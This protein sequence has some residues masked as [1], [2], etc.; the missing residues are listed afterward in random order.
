MGVLSLLTLV[1]VIVI[2]IWRGWNLGVSAVAA[3]MI[4]CMIAGIS[5]S[6]ALRDFDGRMAAQLI[7]S[8]AAFG[9]ISVNGAAELGIKKIMKVLGPKAIP[10]MPWFF[11]LLMLIPAMMGAARPAFVPA[12]A[13]G[14]LVG[15]QLGL[16][17][18]LIPFM[19]LVPAVISPIHPIQ[20]VGIIA[21]D[22]LD[23]QGQ[24]ASLWPAFYAEMVVGF[25]ICLVLYILMKGYKV[26]KD[27]N[28]DFGEEL[29]KFDAKQIMSLLGTVV[30]IVGIVVL[31]LDIGMVGAFMATV[32]FALNIFDRK[33]FFKVLPIDIMITVGGMSV[34]VPI[35]VNMG[36]IDVLMMMLNPILNKYTIVPIITLVAGLVSWLS[37]T[38]TVVLPTFIPI[39]PSMLAAV[40]GGIEFSTLVTALFCGAHFSSMNPYDGLGAHAPTY[41]TP[42]IGEEEVKKLMPKQLMTTLA[43]MGFVLVL[44]ATGVIDLITSLFR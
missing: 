31:K 6:T 11:Y 5:T 9:I 19:C 29:P 35:V 23:A 20:V 34:L 12:I 37:S 28:L 4:L 22:L 1:L 44:S 42:V 8:A 18:L 33:T 16:N 26:N 43:I 15:V 27:A 41:L 36:G 7:F 25:I 13:T 2:S 3:S 14:A 39:L 40:G 21:H 17:P 38:A 10:V 24:A 30:A 32:Y